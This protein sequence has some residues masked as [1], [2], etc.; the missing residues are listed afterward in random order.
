MRLAGPLV[1]LLILLTMAAFAGLGLLLTRIDASRWF[2]LIVWLGYATITLSVP[3]LLSGSTAQVPI[4]WLIPWFLAIVGLVGLINLSV[5]FGW[6]LLVSLAFSGHNDEAAGAT[7]IEKYKQFIRFHLT[8]Q[9]LTGYVI[10]IDEPQIDG[11][12]LKPRIIDVFSVEP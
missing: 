11:R 10:A 7:R 8:P 5:W 9:K 1:L 4:G 3:I 6:Y 12:R 2:Y